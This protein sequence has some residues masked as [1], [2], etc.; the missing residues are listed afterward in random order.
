MLIYP[1]KAPF[2]PNAEL[3]KIWRHGFVK[4]GKLDDVD[5]V[6]VYLTAYLTDVSLDEANGMALDGKPDIVEKEITDM[7]GKKVKKKFIK[8]GRLHMYPPKF[9]LYRMSKGIKP[10]TEEQ[11]TEAEAMKKVG[12]ATPTFERTTELSDPESGFSITINK[13]YYNRNR[14]KGQEQQNDASNSDRGISDRP[15]SS[16]QQPEDPEILQ[17]DPGSLFKLH[18]PSDH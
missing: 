5:N 8:R 18:R 17:A 15:T 12:D 2:I 13:R 6:G 14:K 1:C 9:N 3:A 16:R 11:T 7:N 4:I 10:P